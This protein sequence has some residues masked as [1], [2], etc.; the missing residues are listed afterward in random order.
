MS[1][2]IIVG[3]SLVGLL[4]GFAI[5]YFAGR[6]L[7]AEKVSEAERQARRVLEDAEREAKALKKEKLLELKEEWQRAAP[8]GRA[9]VGNQA[10]PPAGARTRA[11][12]A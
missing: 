7:A 10:Q 8:A 9:G 11:Q 6:R 3:L 12:I 1:V 5:A 2:L 4:A